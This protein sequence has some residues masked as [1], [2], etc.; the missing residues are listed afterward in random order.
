VLRALAGIVAALVVAAPASAQTTI[1]RTNSDWYCNQSISSLAY[2]GLPLRVT[3]NFTRPYADAAPYGLARFGPNCVGDNNRTTTDV[4]LTIQGDRYVGGSDD[5]VRLSNNL[6]GARH[7]VISGRV[8]CGPAGAGAHQDGVQIL[9][10]TNIL[11]RDFHV[12]NASSG[13]STCGGQG[14]AM[15]Y[16][17]PSN[18]IDVLRGTYIACNHSIFADET[19]PGATI[20]G[21]LSRS[22]RNDGT[23]PKCHYYS[24]N[25]CIDSFDGSF[26]PPNTCQRW[27]GGAWVN[28]GVTAS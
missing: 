13:Y 15:Y 16:D 24:S 17:L 3:L 14:G 27:I 9:G 23:D 22:G 21:V 20:T 2:N 28:R 4:V 18:N 8:N 1:V 25:P 26:V 7:L 6:P 10:G 19:S 5:A 12:G 11:F